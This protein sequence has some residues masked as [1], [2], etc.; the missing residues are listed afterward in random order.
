M[1]V[2][3]NALLQLVPQAIAEVTGRRIYL[4]VMVVVACMACVLVTAS[5]IA[6]SA[7]IRRPQSK[8]LWSVTHV[9]DLA[10]L[11]TCLLLSAMFI[12]F[13]LW[14][15]YGD[16]VTRFLLK[17]REPLKEQEKAELSD[18]GQCGK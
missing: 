11:I 17:N 9:L 13:L 1:R 7:C 15:A 6:W 5:V 8:L 4:R 18:N 10:A 12:G 16:N 3:R 2:V 14:T